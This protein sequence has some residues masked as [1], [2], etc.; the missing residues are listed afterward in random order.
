MSSL[1]DFCL[2]IETTELSIFI[3]THEWIIPTLQTLHILCVAVIISS[4]LLVTLRILGLIGKDQT[5]RSFASR[6]L[7]CIWY[8]IPALALGGVLQIAAEPERSLT[9]Y[10]FQ[11]K[12]G[13]L[14]AAMGGLIILGRKISAP[15]AGV[16][17]QHGG[18]AS[19]K[20]LGT[21]VFV[22]WLAIAVAGR[23]IAYAIGL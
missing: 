19:L 1:H 23:W 12:M 3:K 16:E 17:F 22:L 15:A 20:L 9:N 6:F 7:P 11:L 5:I 18:A 10:M 14:I 13:L 2:W 21:A 4:I 8:T